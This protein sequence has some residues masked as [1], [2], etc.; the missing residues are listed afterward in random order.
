MT[1]PPSSRMPTSKETRVRVEDLVKISA[2]DWPASGLGWLSR[3]A[4]E[5]AAFSQDHV[6]VRARQLFQTQQ[7]F[8]NKT[9]LPLPD[10]M[11]AVLRQTP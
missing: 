6:H 10:A 3:A 4:F 2:Q 11:M 5:T 7:V 8:H 9:A 1:W